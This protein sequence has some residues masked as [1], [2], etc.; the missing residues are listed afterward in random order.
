VTA[1]DDIWRIEMKSAF[2][3]TTAMRCC[4]CFFLLSSFHASFE[5]CVQ[6]TARSQPFKSDSLTSD[7]MT[8]ST[9][10]QRKYALYSRCSR[11]FIQLQARRVDARA[12]YDS[13]Y[14]MIRLHINYQQAQL[15]QTD[16]R[17]S[18]AF[19]CSSVTIHN[20]RDSYTTLRFERKITHESYY[21]ILQ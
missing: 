18:F 7:D 19:R 14:G 12:N 5:W 13:I 9:V 15:K 11:S 17:G 2:P 6:R 16:Q 3:G 10:T 8:A 21:E 1:L 4:F 20:N